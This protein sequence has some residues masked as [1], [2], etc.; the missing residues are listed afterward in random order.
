[1]VSFQYAAAL[2][3]PADDKEQ[4]SIRIKIKNDTLHNF[5]KASKF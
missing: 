4:D 3:E 5:E 1:M 2:E